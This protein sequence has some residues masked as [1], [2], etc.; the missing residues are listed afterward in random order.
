MWLNQDSVERAR[1]T[2]P[3]NFATVP[4]TIYWGSRQAGDRQ[5]DATYDEP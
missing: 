4:T 1:I 5:V 3:L 2:T